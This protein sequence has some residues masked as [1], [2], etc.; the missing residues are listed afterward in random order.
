[1]R[2][3]QPGVCTV[4]ARETRLKSSPAVNAD[5]CAVCSSVRALDVTYVDVS[6]RLFT[7]GAQVECSSGDA[8][9]TATE[10]DVVELLGVRTSGT[11]S[12]MRS[13][14]DRKSGSPPL[15]SCVI[16][17]GTRRPSDRGSSLSNRMDDERVRSLS[18]TKEGCSP[19]WRKLSSLRLAFTEKVPRSA[20]AM[21]SPTAPA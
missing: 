1:M 16:V 18:V 21:L 11:A 9:R 7:S 5:V 15:R 3:I 2:C 8:R 4:R 12:A 17:T 14:P 13:D 20:A 10:Y 6:T 19:S